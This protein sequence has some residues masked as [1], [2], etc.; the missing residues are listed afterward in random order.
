MFLAF[1]AQTNQKYI[2]ELTGN[3]TLS[4]IREIFLDSYGIDNELHFLVNDKPIKENTPM[5]EFN[6]TVETPISMLVLQKGIPNH[7]K[8]PPE[9]PIQNPP[10]QTPKIEDKHP[11]PPTFAENV[12]AISEMGFPKEKVEKV[13]RECHYD[14]N[15]AATI[16]A[17]QSEEEEKSD[18]GQEVQLT[19]EDRAAIRRLRNNIYDESFVTDIYLQCNKDEA[20]ARTFLTY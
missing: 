7:Q 2:L 19:R 14:P 17:S 20:Q 1:V 8:P 3:E 15:Q 10:A 18:A 9:P 4:D 12:E 6:F 16:L 11:D 13:L 5:K